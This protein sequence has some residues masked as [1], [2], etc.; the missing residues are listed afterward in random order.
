MD[1]SVE[2]PCEIT[3]PLVDQETQENETISLV[4]VISK[5]RKVTWLKNGQEV[6]PSD[7]FQVSVSED[8]LRHVLTLKGVTK[9][10]VA[11]FTASIDDAS[12]GI[13]TSSCKVNVVGELLI[14]I[15]II[16]KNEKNMW[17][18]VTKTTSK[19]RT[20]L[21]SN[22]DAISFKFVYRHVRNRAAFFR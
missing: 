14:F 7:R 6:V 11:E 8:G 17:R 21:A 15:I 16:S 22:F 3:T 2:L 5:R 4:L 1:A 10:E 20:F 19:L 18:S 9:D 13:I 12:H